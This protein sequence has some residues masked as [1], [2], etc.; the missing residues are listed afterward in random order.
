[1]RLASGGGGRFDFGERRRSLGRL[2]EANRTNQ[3]TFHHIATDKIYIVGN[4]HTI[5]GHDDRKLTGT[6]IQVTCFKQRVLQA[7][8]TDC[9]ASASRRGDVTGV[10]ALGDWN[11]TAAELGEGIQAW[12]QRNIRRASSACH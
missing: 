10:V 8:L 11:L 2:I 4:N 7:V 6:A 5:N 12:Q 9:T 3:A 1:M